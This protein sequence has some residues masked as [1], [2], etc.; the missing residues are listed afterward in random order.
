M[1]VYVVESGEYS[2]CCIR[3][4]F[5]SIEDARKLVK[6]LPLFD[7]PTITEWVVVGKDEDIKKGM[8]RGL[9]NGL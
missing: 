8:L 1:K 7:D 6:E 2:N 9:D 3:A 4:I 5:E